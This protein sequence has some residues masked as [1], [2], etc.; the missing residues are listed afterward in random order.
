LPPHQL[1]Y[2][3]REGQPHQDIQCAQQHVF[4]VLCKDRT[5]VQILLDFSV[6]WNGLRPRGFNLLQNTH[7]PMRPLA[8]LIYNR[9]TS[10]YSLRHFRPKLI[11]HHRAIL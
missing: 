8:S 9:R 1:D 6:T 10:G 5:L 11:Q 3:G 4:R 7:L 2:G